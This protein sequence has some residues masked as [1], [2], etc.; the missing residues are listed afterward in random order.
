M[1]NEIEKEN[2]PVDNPEI[3]DETPRA[4]GTDSGEGG[5]GGADSAPPSAGTTTRRARR[6]LSERLAGIEGTDDEPKFKMGPDVEAAAFK[7]SPDEKAPRIR[8]EKLRESSRQQAIMSV[9]IVDAFMGIVG[10]KF[11]RRMKGPNIR[12]K[13][14]NYE[15]MQMTAKEKTKLAKSIARVLTFYKKGGMHPVTGLFFTVLMIYGGR[16]FN[17]FVADKLFRG[18]K[19]KDTTGAVK[20]IAQK[21]APT[22]EEVKE[23]EKKEAIEESE[24]ARLKREN[25]KMQKM[26]EK[27]NE[28]LRESGSINRALNAKVVAANRKTRTLK[29]ND[30]VSPV[31]SVSSVENSNGQ[32]KKKAA[33]VL[34]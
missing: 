13:E 12:G 22:P 29:K 14:P 17:N 24:V 4:G 2:K 10:D 23:K 28:R 16:L 15:S 9:E 34:A 8:S 19:V 33:P 27:L 26:N 6:T 11:L 21:I 5:A 20:E 1:E 31:D 3:G 25:E 18:H 30:P 32:S 7:S